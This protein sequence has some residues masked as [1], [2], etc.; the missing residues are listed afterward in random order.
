MQPPARSNHR[1][2]RHGPNRWL[3][4]AASSGKA[5]RRQITVM[6]C[7]LVG[8]T[9]LSTRMDPE[10]LRDVIG[11][12]Q[13]RCREAV[14]RYDGFIA[15]YMG[16]GM[17]VYFGFPSAHEDDPQRAVRAGLEMVSS[18]T[19]L[20]VGT[21][22]GPEAHLGVRIGVAT[23]PV[24][25][26]DIV[27][28][29]ASEEAAV[30]GETPNL[31]ARLQ[32]EADINQI[33]VA[34]TTRERI[35]AEFECGDL[36]A[37]ALK[38]IATPVRLWRV[39]GEHKAD[40]AAPARA[41][42]ATLPLVGRAEEL[43]LLQRSW[44]V[45]S[46]G[47]GQVVLIQGEPG[48]GKSRLLQALRGAM[49]MQVHTALTM[50]CSPYHANST[51]FPVI[52]HLKRVIDW[53][54]D[55]DDAKRLDGLEQA[56]ARQSLPL[57]EAVPIFADLLT[58]SLPPE[59]YPPLNLDATRKREHTLN[60][61]I[62]WLLDEA[63]RNPTLMVWEDLHWADPTT[64]DLLVQL[65]EQSPTAS[66]LVAVTYRP[67]FTPR[68]TMRS[69]ITPISLGRLDR[70]AVT[71]FI[72][73]MANDK[74][75]PGEVE[76]YIV[77]KADGNPLYVEELTRTLLES[78]YLREDEERFTLD[79]SL[80][81]IAIP[82]TLQDT[83]MA[84][85]DRL[86]AAR[87]LAQ[88]ASVLGREFPFELL[89]AVTPTDRD[90]LEE[91]LG[92]LVAN[93]ILY[94][95]GRPPRARYF[96]KHALIQ[97]AAYASLLNRTRRNYHEQIARYINGN[98][99]H[100]IAATPE[101]VARHYHEGQNWEDA[102]TYWYRAGRQAAARGASAE[103][104]HYLERGLEALQAL[105]EDDAR[106]RRELDICTTLGSAHVAR[107]GY[108]VPEVGEVYARARALCER[109]GDE[110]SRILS[111]IRGEQ[112]HR[113][114]AGR[115]RDSLDLCEQFSRLASKTGD[116]ALEVGA[117]AMLAPT[118][119]F[120][121]RF[122][123]IRARITRDFSGRDAVGLLPD[124]WPSAHPAYTMCVFRALA[125]QMPGYPDQA[126]RKFDEGAAIALEHG[127]PIT[128][129]HA[130]F[131]YGFFAVARREPEL[132]RAHA[133]EAVRIASEHEIVV[134]REIG[135]AL[136]GWAVGIDGQPEAGISEV[137]RSVENL[138]SQGVGLLIPLVMGLLGDVLVSS[139]R[140]DQTIAALDE[141]LELIGTGGEYWYAAELHRLK[142]EAWRSM[143]DD[144]GAEDCFR[145]ALEVAR[146]QN[147][148]L[149]ELRAAASISQ[150]WRDQGKS[151]AAREL[152]GSAYDWFSEGFDTPDLQR[153][154]ALLDA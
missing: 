148:K 81:E 28:E 150:L 94:Q 116:E 45:G 75:L 55:D 87:G 124:D 92:Q 6:F 30:I 100:M 67:E 20:R 76:D 66:V 42:G 119:F 96:F 131:V 133:T 9:G 39:I 77:E 97:E 112:L 16:D 74:T 10:D 128:T 52:E 113:F 146:H 48:I 127:H 18:V 7:D 15:R 142:G 111:V 33:I 117:D 98:L 19:S 44:E 135:F 32:S 144:A 35:R 106:M 53:D 73:A 8:S 138:Q 149:L 62:G 123:P 82:A 37:R 101:L 83:L 65:I 1:R 154:R 50:R 114:A 120:L 134:H 108:T 23:G 129:S 121:G 21:G 102:A 79:G 27:G 34:N 46:G 84:R 54:P 12:F 71:A 104:I 109:V 3:K 63:E 147:A 14:Q 43:G 85:L 13:D 115:M 140:A 24:V 125:D 137:R 103:A 68:W 90:T 143:A 4:R 69:H 136:H 132:A 17:L 151:E 56:L 152:L 70:P 31:A 118:L 141:G 5:E 139:N 58:I 86:P 41:G 36:G 40:H 72:R 110:D 22:D 80:A 60:A 49:A 61:L 126:R 89:K 99:P 25:V 145:K 57:A 107:S 59:R 47:Q 38:G 11:A 95:R 153:A 88:L 91:D 130:H 26:G 78:T 105:P 51:L 122:E 93:E 2:L 29:G 64:L